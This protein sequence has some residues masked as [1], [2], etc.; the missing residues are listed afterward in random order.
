MIAERNQAR[1]ENNPSPESS[2]VPRSV[3]QKA[4]L[5]SDILYEQQVNIVGTESGRALARGVAY[6][7]KKGQIVRIKILKDNTSP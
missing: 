2:G 7:N 3:R 4:D 6:I 1:L 5:A